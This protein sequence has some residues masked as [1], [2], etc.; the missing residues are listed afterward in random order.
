MSIFSKKKKLPPVN[1]AEN[2]LYDAAYTD[3]E[4]ARLQ[5]PDQLLTE[6]KVE[7]QEWHVDSRPDMAAI[8]SLG[9]T[10]DNGRF[11]Y[12]DSIAALTPE[13]IQQELR[14]RTDTLTE[15]Y[16]KNGLLK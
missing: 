10:G 4:I 6:V 12:Y 13:Q 14:S 8:D 1:P 2:L 16:T 5:N 3:E 7:G 9:Y 11:V 15:Y